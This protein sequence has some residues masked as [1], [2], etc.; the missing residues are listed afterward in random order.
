[1]PSTARLLSGSAVPIVGTGTAQRVLL[2]LF[3]DSLD[4]G[5][6]IRI[7]ELLAALVPRSFKFGRCDVPIR[8]AF[9]ANS[10]QVLA[11]L[12]DRGSSEEP[13][14]IVD[15]MNDKA[16]LQH[17]HVRNHGIV[18]GVGVF[19]DVEILL[20]NA[21]RIGEKGPVRPYSAAIFVRLGDIVGADRDQPAIAYLD[22]TMELQQTFGLTAILW[23]EA[24]ATKHHHH[25]ILSLQL[26]EFS[27]LP[28][29]VAKLIVRESSALRDV[30]SHE[31]LH[32]WVQSGR[33]RH[34]SITTSPSGCEQQ[35]STLPSAGASIG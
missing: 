10:T 6:A 9:L 1:M 13:V 15:L 26:G 29:V 2:I 34:K 33:C 32:G 20:N 35:I 23:T 3:A 14:A 30:G 11:E 17:N 28:G 31:F 24:A 16:G 8:S 5:F 7:E 25:R 27:M 22:L 12:F 21:P 19:R 4:I 18:D